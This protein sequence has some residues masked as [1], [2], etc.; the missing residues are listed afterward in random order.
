MNNTTARC[1]IPTIR[2]CCQFIAATVHCYGPLLSMRNPLLFTHLAFLVFVLYSANVQHIVTPEK[3][4]PHEMNTCSF[5]CNCTLCTIRPHLYAQHKM[6]SNKSS[7][8]ILIMKLKD[9]QGASSCIFKDQFST[10]VYSMDSCITAIFNVYFCDDV[11]VLLDKNLNMTII[12]KCS[13]RQ[14]TWQTERPRRQETW[15]QQWR[16]PVNKHSLRICPRQMTAEA[17]MAETWGG[18]LGQRTASPSAPARE[19]GG[20]L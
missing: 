14:H 16:M 17:R 15:R 6:W 10:E 3:T 2:H 7:H 18:V 20:V 11:T 8:Y 5:M 1:K 12:S 9:F 13:F 4:Q 19:P